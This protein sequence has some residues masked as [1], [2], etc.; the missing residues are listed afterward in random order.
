MRLFLVRSDLAFTLLRAAPEGSWRWRGGVPVSEPWAVPSLE[1]VEGS[2]EPFIAADCFT[3]NGGSDGLILSDFARAVLDPVLSPAGEFWP[4]RV[5]ERRYWW[6][7]CIAC[8][9]AL[10]REATDAD[11]GLVEGGWGSFRWITTTRRLGFKAVVAGSAPALFR[12]P[13]YPQGALFCADALREVVARHELTGFQFDLV[14]T[15]LEGGVPNPP[16][17]GLGDAFEE[18]KA[19]DVARRRARA[20][21]ILGARKQTEPRE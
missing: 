13:E 19:T 5:L 18:M 9:D 15:A 11:W 6:F 20:V 10:D 12:V 1:A 14:W 3:T 8:V 4:V 7:N 17:V 16:G 2:A 21:T